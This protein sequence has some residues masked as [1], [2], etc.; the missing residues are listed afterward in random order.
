MVSP[1]HHPVAPNQAENVV[2]QAPAKAAQKPPAKP[3]PVQ[4]SVKLSRTSETGHDSSS[5]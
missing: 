3:Q 2:N 1:V 5:K 4:D